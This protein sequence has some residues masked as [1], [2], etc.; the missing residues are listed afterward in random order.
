MDRGIAI[1]TLVVTTL[2]LFALLAVKATLDQKKAEFEASPAGK[3][4]SRLGLYDP[5]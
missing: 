4:A 1:A 3:I 2:T 5:E